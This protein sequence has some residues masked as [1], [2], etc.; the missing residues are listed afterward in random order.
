MFVF[1]FTQKVIF[2]VRCY[3]YLGEICEITHE[4]K[5]GRGKVRASDGTVWA[6]IGEDFPVKT[7]VEI[8]EVVEAMLFRVKVVY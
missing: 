1:K 3:Y 7:E 2:P 4:I 6:V 5:H 8:V